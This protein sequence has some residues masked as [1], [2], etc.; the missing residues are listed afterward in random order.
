MTRTKHIAPRL[1][2]LLLLGLF[3]RQLYLLV[4][5]LHPALDFRSGFLPLARDVEWVWAGALQPTSIRVNARLRRAGE[6]VRLRLSRERGSPADPIFSE[7][8]V[9]DPS[10]QTLSIAVDGLEP[11]TRYFYALEVDGRLDVARRGTFRTPLDGPQSF[12]FAFGACAR[13]GSSHPVFT[14]IGRHDP[15]FLLHLGDLHYE[16]IHKNEPAVYVRAFDVVLGSASQSRLYRGVP[17]AYVWDDHDFGGNNSDSASSSRPA[18]QL[19]YRQMVPHYPLPASAG[20]RAIYQAFTIGRVRFILTDSRSEKT[21]RQSPDGPAK[22]LLGKAQKEWLKR[23][24]LAARDRYPLIVWANTLPWI[25]KANAG[26]DHW[27]GYATERM[28]LARFI[29]DNAVEQL[30]MLSGDAHMLAIDD[31]RNNRPTAGG[32]PGFP[33]FHAG[34]FDQRGSVKGGPYSSGTFPGPGH[35]GLMTVEDDGGETVTV[36]WSGRDHRDRELL[37]HSFVAG[38]HWGSGAT[39]TDEP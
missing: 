7:A 29:E 22:T 11:G 8:R 35:F 6:R 37:A 20:G 32:E 1:V 10:H 3:L 31:G 36:R 28:E 13:T 27:G 18:A 17:V 2:L 30:V 19:A 9:P 34:A 24:L 16:N 12:T 26:A 15:L 23:E 39:N 14:T 25:A 4:P 21:P 33:V 5:L 38:K